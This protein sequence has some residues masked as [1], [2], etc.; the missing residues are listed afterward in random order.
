MLTQ[1]SAEAAAEAK[2]SQDK[3]QKAQQTFDCL[4][5][6]Q[7]HLESCLKD[8]EE[9][10]QQIESKGAESK[11]ADALTFFLL[12]EAQATLENARVM[13]LKDLKEQMDEAF[14][15]MTVALR[16]AREKTTRFEAVQTQLEN[17]T[18]ERDSLVTSR[19]TRVLEEL[20]AESAAAQGE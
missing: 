18:S 7:A 9:V 16:D 14:Q 17:E 4:K 10:V 1:A 8:V 5:T 11:G 3:L 19:R 13:S 6:R 15:E 12:S 2:T 20:Q